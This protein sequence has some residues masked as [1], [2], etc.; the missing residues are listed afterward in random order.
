MKRRIEIGLGNK[1][2]QGEAIIAARN[3]EGRNT[4]YLWKKREG[5]RK[6]GNLENLSWIND[7]AWG[8]QAAHGMGTPA[9]ERS[10]EG[11]QFFYSFY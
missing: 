3:K 9:T 10:M 1:I 11:S 5:R 8:L 4:N 2:I 7:R 6:N